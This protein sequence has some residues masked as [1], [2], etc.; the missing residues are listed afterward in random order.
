MIQY[1]NENEIES[2]VH[3]VG[4]I[5]H[6]SLPS[7]YACC[8]L[9]CLSSKREGWPNVLLEAMIFGK[10]VVA[11]NV[12]GVPEVVCSEDY[13]ILVRPQ[14]PDMLAGGLRR[15]LNKEWNHDKIRDWAQAHTW[16]SVGRRY[17]QIYSNAVS[18]QKSAK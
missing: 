7:Y 11:T 15:A 17:L 3:I 18:A 13:G 2:R 8:N 14:N 1:C 10:P 16:E 9:L 5:E 6:D 4:P 12:G